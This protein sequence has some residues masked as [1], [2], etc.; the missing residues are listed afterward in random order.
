[1]SPYWQNNTC[2][3]FEANAGSCDLGNLAPYAIN[4]DTAETAMAGMRFAREHNLRLTVKNT[5]H[6]F[7]GRSS[8]RGALELWTH[9]LKAISFSA[10]RSRGYTGPAATLGAGVQA[11]EAYAA[12]H[13]HGLRIVGGSCASVGL[14]G[15]FVQGGG[16]GPLAATYGMGVDNALEFDVVTADGRRRTA[17]PTENPD[18]F[19]ALSGG[20][21]G[22]WA[23]VLSLTTKAH[24]DGRVGGATMTFTNSD[25]AKFWA[26]VTA[27]LRLQPSLNDIPNFSSLWLLT[28][29]VFRISYVTLADGTEADVAKALAPFVQT[30]KKI[31]IVPV[32]YQTGESPGFYAHLQRFNRDEYSTNSSQGSRLI[33]RRA[34]EQDLPALVAAFRAVV[35]EPSVRA[36]AVAG[37]SNDVSH[38]RV[39]N[40]PGANALL[41]AWRDALFTANL[42]SALDADAA[43][44]ELARVQRLVNGWQARTRPFSPGGGAYM[45]EATFDAPDWK[46]DYYGT[47]YPRLEG[48]KQRYDPEHL[49]WVNAGVGSDT[50]WRLG[51]DGRL[52]RKA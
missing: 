1:M 44:P 50:Y 9:N 45:N 51:D 12:A 43:P 34:V 40:R 24:P 19:W 25:D 10:Y 7:L 6:D 35:R 14:A 26:G 39:G 52:C 31:G 41:P 20:G 3:P 23:L 49:F 13:E 32:D 4:V 22:N 2:S 37:V 28:K 15:G 17:S 5:G 8:G 27:W 30:L 21:A 46:A 16:H 48:I 42:A 29:D 47:T 33:S 36:A 38:R 11:F 18:L